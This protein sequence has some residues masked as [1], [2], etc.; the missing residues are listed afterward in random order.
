MEDAVIDQW[1]H[2][3]GVVA[4]C[5]AIALTATTAMAQDSAGTVTETVTTCRDVNGRDAACKKVVTYRAR[6][7]GEE[8][9]VVE[10]YRPSL[11]A[12]R[13]AL[14]RRVRRTTTETQDGSRTVEET[15]ERNPG[16]PGEPLRVVQ[17]RVTT[18]H[19]SG[20]DS[21]VSE[22]QV[23]EPDGNGRLVLR[24]SERTPRN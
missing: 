17:R 3:G 13:L 19:Q 10:T 22:R 16:S 2:R 12:D 18:L 1:I 7:N 5:C 11:Y 21:Y 9:V 6:T 15:E 24:Q 20:T 8:R 4:V 14:D 23:F